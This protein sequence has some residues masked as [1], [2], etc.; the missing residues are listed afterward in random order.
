MSDSALSCQDEQRRDSV[1]RSQFYGLDYLEVEEDHKTLT[2]TFLGKAPDSIKQQNVRI[3]GGSR[4]TGIEVTDDPEVHRVDDPEADDWM[5][6]SVNRQG[7]FST[8]TLRLVEPGGDA[9]MDGF[10]KRYSSIEFSF[11]VECPSDLDCKVAPICPPP[12]Q[13]APEINYLAKD[14]GSFRQLIL[15]RLALVM[16]D[17]RE[18]NPAD[19]GITLVEM[20]AYVGDQL[21]YYQDAVATEAYLNTARQRTSVRRHA[22]LVDYRIHEGCNARVW[23]C[24][25]SSEPLDLGRAHGLDFYMITRVSHAQLSSERVLRQSE[26]AGIDASSYEAFEIIQDSIHL[27]PA[28]R[29]IPFYT[30]GDFECCLPAGATRATLEGDAETLGLEPGAFL[31]LEEIISPTTGESADADP[32]HRHVVRLTSVEAATDPL[33]GA[34][35]VEIGWARQDALP[36]PLCLSALSGPP[37]CA[38]FLRISVARGNTFLADHGLWRAGLTPETVPLQETQQHCEGYCEGKGAL[39]DPARLPGRFRPKLLHGPL[40]CSQPVPANS[41]AFGLLRQDPRQCNPAL[42]VTDS[43]QRAWAAQPDLLD[44]GADDAHF[45]VEPG[46]AAQLRFGDGD[47]GRAP[48]PESVFSAEYRIGIGKAGHIG[49]NMLRH[50]VF[51]KGFVSELTARNPLAADGGVEPESMAEIKQ[52]APFAFRN[53]IRRAITPEDYAT[54]AQAPYEPRV[55]RAEARFLWTGSWYE[56]AVVIDPIA[57]VAERDYP[58]LTKAVE[59]HLYRYRRIG[60]DVQVKIARSVAVELVLDVCVKTG[61]L[62]GHVEAALR[63]AFSNRKLPDGRKGFF[64]PDN[65][66]LGVGIAVSRIVAAAQAVEGVLS[67]RVRTLNR[68]FEPPDGELEMGLLRVQPWEMPRLDNDPSLPE[69]GTLKINL[70]GGR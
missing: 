28:Q 9:P 10:D 44:S 20:L 22:R 16:P 51:R 29:E 35:L 60:H 54:L 52:F 2:V 17:W 65:L 49:A 25:D 45:V 24:L 68:K 30:W 1:R 64:F 33:T 43:N 63:D 37:N 21:S 8:Y 42:I 34:A 70:R 7:D 4:V 6:I 46:D 50:I 67:V 12:A 27:N 31:L 5:V 48:D 58:A 3:E 36:F 47:L 40:T 11:M 14:Y 61:F 19:I 69:N 13:V 66:H 38:P 15:D 18:R 41:P 62:R 23:V 59:R 53:E 32:A 55:Q 57:E 39:S 26:L 56:V